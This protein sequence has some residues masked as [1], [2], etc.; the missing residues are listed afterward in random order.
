VGDGASRE[1][2]PLARSAIV[3][4]MQAADSARRAM[5]KALQPFD[6]TLPQFNVLTILLHNEEL[7]TFQIAARMVEATPG[8]TR[9][10]STLETKGYVQRSQS[11]EDRRQQ[12]CSLTPEGRRV[13]NAAV[14]PFL[15][16]QQQLISNL[17]RSE[18]RQMTALLQRVQAR[19]GQAFADK[20]IVGPRR[21]AVS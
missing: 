11:R 8:I 4:L 15:A 17:T 7:P 14:P 2:V 5:G 21:R 12:I 20:S 9:L 3:A 19:D 18:A 13:V 16:A 1:Q 6:L 10:V